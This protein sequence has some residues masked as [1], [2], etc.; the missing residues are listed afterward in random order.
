MGR[1][2]S[3]SSASTG[4]ESRSSPRA[5]DSAKASSCPGGIFPS[6]PRR[7]RGPQRLPDLR[8]GGQARGERGLYRRS[9]AGSAARQGA[10]SRRRPD[11][12]ATVAAPA[13]SASPESSRARM[14]AGDWRDPAAR[15]ASKIPATRGAPARPRPSTRGGGRAA[16]G[17]DSLSP[18]VQTRR[19]RSQPVSPDAGRRSP[20]RGANA[21]V[22]RPLAAAPGRSRGPNRGLE[23]GQ[24][25]RRGS[26]RKR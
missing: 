10:A 13:A 12:P 7:Q 2:A 18:E 21:E 3:G 5:V 4:R 26:P 1:A 9:S 6:A 16:R 24:R 15:S 23:G 22:P 8:P 20:P 11:A 17:A 19:K 25:P 14:L